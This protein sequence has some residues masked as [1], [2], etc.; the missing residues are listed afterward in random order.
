MWLVKRERKKQIKMIL[1]VKKMWPVTNDWKLAR[2]RI[3]WTVKR[4]KGKR[5]EGRKKENDNKN[6][7]INK[8]KWDQNLR[9]QK[10]KIKEF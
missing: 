1:W 7:K 6:Q 10:K 2:K 9:S 4:D 8:K 5:N 3:N